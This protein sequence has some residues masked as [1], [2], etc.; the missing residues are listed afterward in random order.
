MKSLILKK[1]GKRGKGV[2]AGKNYKKGETIL[3][4]KGKIYT[5]K[6]FLKE[7]RWIRDHSV[8][9]GKNLFM[10]P[11]NDIEDYVNHSCDPVAGHRINGK[12]SKFI[13]I[14]NVK[15]GQEITFDYSTTM[16]KTNEAMKCKCGSSKCRKMITDFSDLPLKTRKKYISLRIVPEYIVK[17]LQKINK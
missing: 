7:S 4:P 1:S 11:A 3:I 6:Q 8:Q 9:I 16:Y 12:K 5:R 17:D 14:K 13:A 10:G 2:F 15:K